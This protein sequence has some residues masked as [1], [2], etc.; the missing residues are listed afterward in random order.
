MTKS[1]IFKMRIVSIL[2]L[3]LLTASSLSAQSYKDVETGV[4]QKLESA[5][6]EFADLQESIADEKIPLA[7]KLNALEREVANLKKELSG[8]E[9]LR[10]SRDLNLSS[11]E[12]EIKARREDLD[13]GKNLL[14][15]FVTNQNSA[16]D[17]A[18]R[19]LYESQFMDILATADSPGGDA[20][21]LTGALNSLSSGVE[22]G[23]TRLNSLIGG[24]TFDG[25]A[26]LPNGK[27]EK[28]EFILY[29]PIT[30]FST[31]DGKS[32][33][34]TLAGDSGE[35]TL[36]GLS[37]SYAE[38]GSS[39]LAGSGLIPLD[40]TLGKA[41]A[42]ETTKESLIEHIQKGGFWIYPILLIAFLSIII[43]VFKFMELSRIKKIPKDALV[44][45]LAK[46]NEG[47]KDE[48]L[49][50]AHKLSGESR[51]LLEAAVQNAQYGKDLVEQ[52][53]EEVLMRLQPKL[54]RLLSIIWITAATAPLLGLLGTV[55]GIITTFKLL[56]IFG[57]GDPKALG[58]GI[59][60]ALITTEFGLIVAIPSLILHAFLQRRAKGIEN[61]FESDA[62]MLLNG[63]V[64][65][66]K[67]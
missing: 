66:S 46:L 31:S 51:D 16:S 10:D 43:A 30:L 35:P 13:Y 41:L 47:K 3:S 63:I 61:E 9:R 27:F 11:L 34:I 57:S 26:V 42:L 44:T 45:V 5:L 33:G 59:S 12:N 8:L 1:Q 24:Y 37:D 21:E 25:S 64:R 28:G 14:I 49:A 7:K 54:E 19:Q 22:L 18:E 6:T 48:A 56:T 52:S 50:A 40:P 20:E 55:T 4:S 29:G 36:I 23:I 62:M 2:S 15:E 60:E 38:M 58:G 67:K 65:S 53:L 32:A 39:V 17:A